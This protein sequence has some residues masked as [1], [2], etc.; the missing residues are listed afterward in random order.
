MRTEHDGSNPD[1]A[2][3]T[4]ERYRET[5]AAEASELLAEL[6]GSLLELER[7]PGDAELIARVFRS[8][9][10]IKGS[11]GMVG[12][13]AIASFTHKVESV[14]DDVREGRTAVTQELIG[15]TLDARDH[16][17]ALLQYPDGPR[18]ELA[19]HSESILERLARFA[20]TERKGADSAAADQSAALREAVVPDG[21]SVLYRIGF[22]PAQDILLDGTNPLLLLKELAGLGECRTS[23]HLEG[24]PDLE[25]FNP[26][27][28]YT[29]W[30]VLL[31]TAVDENAIRDVFVFVEDKAR[32]SVE[33]AG[34]DHAG[35]TYFGEVLVALESGEAAVDRG[36]AIEAPDS[37]AAGDACALDPGGSAPAIRRKTEAA[38]SLRVPAGKLDSMVDVVGELVTVQARLSGYASSRGDSE[39]TFIAEEVER[40]TELLR[41]TTMSL[42]MLPIGDTFVRFKRLVRDLAADLGKEV[43]LTT[44]GDDTEL[45]KT[46]IEQLGD[47]LVHLI[48]NAVDHGIEPTEER[49]RR[50]KP[51]KGR[52]HLSACHAGGFVM[53]RVEDDGAGMDRDAIRTRAVERGIVRPDAVLTDEEIFALTLA[54]G[55][56]TVRQVTEISG[57]GVG[58]DVVQR[59]MELLRGTLSIASSAGRGTA[60]TLKIPLT[61]AIIDGLLVEVGDG[62]FVVPLSNI[63]E[64][65]EL[66]RES[67]VHGGKQALVSVRGELVPC[68]GLRERFALIGEPPGI[69]Q[70]IV[71]ETREGRFGLVVDR[72][73][74]DH[75]T[76]IKKLGG[77]YRHVE[78]VSGATILGDGTVALVLDVD[79]IAQEAVRENVRG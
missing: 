70:V 60:V 13:D 49:I 58:M 55:F 44:D 78:E 19:V 76:V 42:R 20:G 66:R 67:R 51:G 10:T 18:G 72:V 16:I 6:E 21:P 15:I 17:Q 37:R 2:L 8:L 56:S 65:I 23:A 57:R 5:Y 53:I 64:C 50:G 39:I 62:R 29:R 46:V 25:E 75:Q 31:A 27:A 32:L 63:S 35:L 26:E 7:R 73:V 30:Q 61:L 36:R 47:P 22:E 71:A 45:D 9:H 68:I 59:G 41:E 54:P 52:V 48:R 34:E 43:E 69:E 3:R 77:L 1:T 40:L 79:K 33:R 24:I 14:F 74:G 28:C 11:G 12:L 4:M 38:A